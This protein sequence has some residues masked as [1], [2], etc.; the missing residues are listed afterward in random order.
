MPAH[1]AAQ[2]ELPTGQKSSYEKAPPHNSVQTAQDEPALH[3]P[4][5]CMLYFR[6]QVHTYSHYRLP[7]AET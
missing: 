4:V 1:N 2:A 6:Y 3:Q 7:D 5:Y